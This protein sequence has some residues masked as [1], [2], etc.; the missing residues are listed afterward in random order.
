[1]A[2][3]SLRHAA[4]GFV[5]GMGQ[6]PV[7]LPFPQLGQGELQQGQR[8]RFLSQVLQDA[9]GQTLLQLHPQLPGGVLDSGFQTG[10]AQRPEQ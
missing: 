5:G 8:A 3:Q 10:L 4:D 7:L 2:G 9:L 6:L 1:M